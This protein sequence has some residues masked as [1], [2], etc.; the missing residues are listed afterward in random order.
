MQKPKNEMTKE[1]LKIE[2]ENEK[3]GRSSS[4]SGS[5]ISI[6]MI[7]LSM[8][9]IITSETFS[10]DYKIICEENLYKNGKIIFCSKITD[11]STIKKKGYKSEYL[12]YEVTTDFKPSNTNKNYTFS[13]YVK[14]GSIKGEYNYKTNPEKFKSSKFK[15]DNIVL[16]KYS[17][18]DNKIYEVEN[19]KPST[20]AINYYTRPV[21]EYN[22]A[23]YFLDCYADEEF[24]KK[25]SQFYYQYCGVIRVIKAAK[26]HN[27]EENGLE[28]YKNCNLNDTTLICYNPNLSKNFDIS[29]L[30]TLLF[31]QNVNP[32]FSK[33]WECMNP[34]YQTEE[35]RNK[36]SDYGYFLHEKVWTKEEFEY[37]FF[38]LKNCFY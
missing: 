15:P 6:S 9:L 16:I 14:E 26:V 32:N 31:Y 29:T 20:K 8:I 19:S 13:E 36:I 12:I 22:S 28:I 38:E 24:I 18:V 35:N 34:K 7:I 21:I 17:Y 2:E 1:E 33:Y 25:N 10:D 11:V 23:K 30:D 5:Q 27:N 4:V 3:E 37:K